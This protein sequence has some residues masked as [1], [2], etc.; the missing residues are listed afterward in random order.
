MTPTIAIFLKRWWPA[1]AGAA[2]FVAILSLA[3]CKGQSAGRSG[4]VIKQQ[5]REIE[6][7][8]DL[9]RANDKAGAQRLD[10]AMKSTKQEKE[11]TDALNATSDPDRQRAL[12][13][14]II[15]RQQGRDTSNIP[16]CR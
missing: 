4:E 12:R 14:C 1:L 2:V 3:Y 13:G 8:Q 5:K 9:G 6:V 10:D 7:Q 16:A 11:L 15:L